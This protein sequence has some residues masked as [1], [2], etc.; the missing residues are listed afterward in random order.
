MTMEW[1][2]GEVEFKPP[3]WLAE[4]RVCGPWWWR[5]VEFWIDNGF[6]K[7]GPFDTL[8]DAHMMI[9]IATRA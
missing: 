8:A 3:L 1:M 5:R 9:K 7:L 4:R 2:I 6:V